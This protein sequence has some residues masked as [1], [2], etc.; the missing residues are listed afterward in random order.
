MNRIT[1]ITAIELITFHNAIRKHPPPPPERQS[2]RKYPDCLLVLVKFQ[3]TGRQ[4]LTK[5]LAKSIDTKE[6]VRRQLG[7]H[8][9]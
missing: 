1:R 9:D 7:C 5:S 8:G 6:K 4:L 3:F 2:T